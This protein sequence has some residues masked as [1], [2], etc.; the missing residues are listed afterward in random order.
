[1]NLLSDLDSGYDD[2]YD[3]REDQLSEKSIKIISD[4]RFGSFK[5]ASIHGMQGPWFYPSWIFRKFIKINK[6]TL[7]EINRSRIPSQRAYHLGFGSYQI[8]DNP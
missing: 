6:N 7:W 5:T 8:L 2:A 3:V 4:L 1:M